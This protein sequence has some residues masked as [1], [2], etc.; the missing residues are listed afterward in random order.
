MK[1]ILAIRNTVF[2]IVLF[3]I[4]FA[5]VWN[6][7]FDSGRLLNTW[8]QH[9]HSSYMCLQD[10]S[11]TKEAFDFALR[12]YYSLKCEGKLENDK[13][14][15]IVDF[16]KHSSKK[17]FYLINMETFEVERKTYCSHG[18]NTGQERAKYFSNRSGSL[19]SSLGFF[20]ANE[21][22]SGKFDYAMRLDGIESMNFRARDRG[23]VVHGAEYATES[24][25]KQNDNVL[26]RS[27]GCPALPKEESKEIIDFIKGGSC[28]FIYAGQE[29]Y[30][31]RSKL[32]RP[33]RFLESVQY[34]I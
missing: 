33:N 22:Y 19:Q 12:G 30:E 3:V 28:F 9:V 23:I 13:Y 11:L 32:I 1:G 20:I 34:F 24:F 26:G 7:P 5:G 8:N 21:T 4:I 10:T 31:K 27:F 18:K 2:T 17:R 15:T 14:L 29:N 16:T 6:E 25:L